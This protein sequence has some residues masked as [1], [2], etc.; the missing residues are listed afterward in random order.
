MSRRVV[1]PIRAEGS[2]RGAQPRN[3]ARGP[4]VSGDPA[5]PGLPADPLRHPGG[6]PAGWR[7]R[8]GGRVARPAELGLE[9][10][11]RSA[12]AA[13]VAPPPGACSR[14]AAS[15]TTP[16]RSSSPAWIGA[17]RT[18]WSRTSPAASPSPRPWG[19]G[20]PGRG[21][22]RRPL[23]PQHGFPVR[24]LVP[25]WY[26]MTKGEVAL[27]R[28]AG[29]PPRSPACSGPWPGPQSEPCGTRPRAGTSCAAGR[30][31]RRAAPS[32]TSRPGTW[33]ATPPTPCSASR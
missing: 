7:L 9:E 12:P 10:T 5:R 3:A 2:A 13:G 27:G 8:V 6:R 4:A 22:R 17:P 24:L 20:D 16:S 15:S 21:A 14:S 1:D 25:G 30:P 28:H 11:R 26:G 23:P 31:T 18:A 29:R 32:R 33:A 19:R